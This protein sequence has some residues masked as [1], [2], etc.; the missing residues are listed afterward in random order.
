[1]GYLWMV[2]MPR[3]TALTLYEE[4]KAKIID[5]TYASGVH[6][7]ESDL[8]EEYKVSR[9]TV[10][11]V[12]RLLE[13]DDL[14]ESLPHKGVRVRKVEYAEL[15]EYCQ[16]FEYLDAMAARLLTERR[17]MAIIGELQHILQEDGKAVKEHNFKAHV[18]LIS[19]LHHVIARGSGNAK[20]YEIQLRISL[21]MQM[22]QA[23]QVLESRMNQSLAS[24]RR[25]I[26]AIVSGNPEQAEH[27]M[28]EHWRATTQKIADDYK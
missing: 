24:H 10:R 2:M 12:L 13:G 26:E 23:V 15:I 6:L 4:I 21:I 16:I 3:S 7:V 11:E 17:D 14:L 28:K 1:M 27:M 25:V 20:L 19:E 8:V 22:P 5:G 9:I 18:R